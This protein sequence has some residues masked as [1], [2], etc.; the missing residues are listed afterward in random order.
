MVARNPL[1]LCISLLF[2]ARHLNKWA[3]YSLLLSYRLFFVRAILHEY[4]FFLTQYSDGSVRLAHGQVWRRMGHV[5]MPFLVDP[6][7]CCHDHRKVPGI[8]R[9]VVVNKQ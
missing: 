8:V 5:H 6:L 1:Y 4:I 3:F 7:V 2:G 9:R